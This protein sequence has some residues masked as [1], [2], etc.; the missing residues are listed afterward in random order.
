MFNPTENDERK[1]LKQVLVELGKYLEKIETEIISYSDK[2]IESKKRAWENAEALDPVERAAL[3]ISVNEDSIFGERALAERNRLQ[4]LMVS[5]YFG[6]IDFCTLEVDG[7]AYEDTDEKP[8]YIGIHSYFDDSN[9]HDVVIDWRAPIASVFYDYETGAAEYNAPEGLIAGE[10]MR[11]RQY[12]IKK[13]NME[14]MLETDLNIGDDILQQE[15]SKTS[16]D[17]MKNIVATIQKEQNQIIR[18]TT[19]KV[20]IIQGAAGSGKTS[21]ALHRVAFLLY[22]NRHTLRA[23]DVLV[24]SPNKV[25]GSYISSVLPELGEENIPQIGFEDIARKILGRSQKFQSFAEQVADLIDSA[26][27]KMVER[28]RYK[29]TVGFVN[30]LEKFLIYIETTA[31]NPQNLHVESFFVSAETLRAE[32]K[33]FPHM[34]IKKRL[35]KIAADR[36]AAYRRMYD[37]PLSGTAVRKIKE[38][39]LRMFR[40]KN[41]REIY[42]KFYETETRSGML[43]DYHDKKHGKLEFCDVFPLCYVHLFF[44]GAQTRYNEINHLLIDEMQDYTPIQ[45]A[46]I[47]KLFSCRMT[48]LGDSH[49]SVNPY[50][51]SSMQSI[52]PFFAG[53]LQ[54]ELR[55]S[56]RS[57]IEITNFSLKICEN[58]SIIPIERHGDEPTVTEYDDEK[59]E[60]EAICKLIADYKTGEH[61]SLGIITKSQ[62]QAAD[63]HKLIAKKHSE[64]VLLDFASSE[65]ADGVVVLSCHMAKGLEF[66]RVIVPDCTQDNYRTELDRSLLY[67]ACTRAMHKLDLTCTWERGGCSKF[68]VH[69]Q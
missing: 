22:R 56:Y 33:R 5:P 13:G 47:A 44:E 30:E 29:A 23:E 11:K 35:E 59:A 61:K 27:E 64:I 65:F 8:C 2:L 41:S 62:K 9:K 67:I 4:K 10:I 19:A 20:L 7:Y 66:D 14:Y 12:S 21:I 45:Y 36:I 3:R 52:A 48:I 34:P 38:E 1:Y 68:V 54:M 49:Q 39:I 60:V 50:T 25:F 40:F 28:I 31:F 32:Y 37:R 46:L 15:L 63:L 53:T 51:S 18:D 26:D 16:D 42:E 57:T 69:K 6:R 58:K 43:V 55:R 17:K 24:I